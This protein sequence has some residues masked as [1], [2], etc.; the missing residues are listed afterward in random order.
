MFGLIDGNN[1]YVSCERAFD[2][3]LIGKPVIVLSNNDGCAIARSAEAK[4]LGIKM[5]DVWH[6]SKH[7]P[8]YRGVIAKSSNYALYGDMSRRVFEVLSESFARVEPYSIDEMF[9]DL[10]EFARADYCRRV[11]E[12]IR[13]VTKI[14]TCVGIGPTKTL[15][16]LANKHAK[17]AS[18]VSDFSDLDVRREAFATMPINEIWGIGRASQAKLNNFGIFT[19]EQFAALTSASVRKLM[20]VTGQR[21]HA[22]LNGVSCLPLALAPSQRQTVAVT[23]MFGR[24]VETWED[25]REALAAH[26]SRA[27]E[28]C[29]NHGLVANA[30]V[31]FFH[32]HPHNGDPWYHGQRSFEIEPTSDSFALI[33]QAVRAGRSMWRPN[34]RYA[35]AGVILLDLK[36]ARDMPRDLLPTADTVRSE[37]LMAALDAVN[38]RFGSGTLRPGGIRQ[39]TPWST[40][41]ANRSPRYTTR[42][43]DLMEVRA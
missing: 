29:R 23:R 14:P 31:V 7:K 26:A 35:K 8:E 2:P 21:T 13:R 34:T 22:E 6:L 20:T 12:R 25:M 10:T 39:V 40:R 38:N 42:L 17:T 16:K 24:L 4:A 28:K 11:R 18:G 3:T 37:K 15:A 32:T 43:S 41:A 30:M 36:S 33:R 1:F 5:G 9:V 27:A 19:V